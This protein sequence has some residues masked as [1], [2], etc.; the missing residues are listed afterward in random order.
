MGTTKRS[1]GGLQV[2]CLL[3]WGVAVHADDANDLAQLKSDANNLKQQTEAA[4][5]KATEFL[6]LSKELRSKDDSE[7]N[8]L[9]RGICMQ[10]IEV[11]GDDADRI[12]NDLVFDS[13]SEISQSFEVMEERGDDLKGEL[14]DLMNA[15]KSTMD[16]YEELEA[17]E[18]VGDEAEDLIEQLMSN[19][20][21]VNRR[22]SEINQ[23]YQ[24]L[25][26]VQ[27][28]VMKG[29]NNPRIRA[30]LDYG[31][32]MHK[33]MQDSLNCD[34]REV[35]VSGGRADCVKFD[36][37]YGCLVIEI[38]PDTYSDNEARSQAERYISGLKSMYKDNDKAK[39]YCKLDSS[40]DWIFT[41]KSE[42]YPACKP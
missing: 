35:S 32:D 41:A 22:W 16:R 19:L 13:V 15:I 1:L 28:G 39:Q 37:S 7:L 6:N 14:E 2:L 9:I 23:D 20:E 8:E 40:G 17:S 33:K 31:K 38:K 21:T 36:S 24:T 42:S 30:S 3:T 29:A 27:N 4:T 10:D 18:E 5:S 12:A 11:S 34:D 26:N 25:M